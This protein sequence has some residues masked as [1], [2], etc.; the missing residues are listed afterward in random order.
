[1]SSPQQP[2]GGQPQYPGQP[3]QPAYPQ[4]PP[5]GYPQQGYP[6]QAGY[7]PQQMAYPQAY[8]PQGHQWAYPQQGYPQGPGAP[9]KPLL[10]TTATLNVGVALFLG[11][12]GILLAVTEGEE[13]TGE[14]VILPASITQFVAYLIM[15]TSA[16]LLIFAATR[17][18]REFRQ[19]ALLTWLGGAVGIAGIVLDFVGSSIWL[20]MFSKNSEH[21]P[22]P[23][24]ADFL[25]KV[26]DISWFMLVA[27]LVPLVLG[28][29]P[30]LKRGL[31]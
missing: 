16:G 10:M 28:L 26:R 14:D 20:V 29:L 5:Q 24:F 7:P 17:L 15:L 23:A 21:L 18:Y 13:A 25:D 8:P 27:A 1:M 31:R 30:A 4:Q 9:N 22:D 11:I 6:Q 12:V 19:G 2:Y 3:Q